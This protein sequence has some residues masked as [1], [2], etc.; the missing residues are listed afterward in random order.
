MALKGVIFCS[1]DPSDGRVCFG[2]IVVLGN[3]GGIPDLPNVI[4]HA[5]FQI[6]Q[7]GLD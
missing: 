2:F 6:F 1:T 5:I 3:D 4:S 7:L